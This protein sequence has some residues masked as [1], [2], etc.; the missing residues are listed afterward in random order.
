[1]LVVTHVARVSPD[2]TTLSAVLFLALLL[3][4]R[5]ISSET[6]GLI[7]RAAAYLG[8]VLLVYLDVSSSDPRSWFEPASWVLVGITA[9]ASLGAV[10]LDHRRRFDVTA[11]DLL[12]VVLA[13]LI[14]NLPGAMTLQPVQAA[15]ITKG[16]ILVYAVEI[17]HHVELRPVVKAGVVATALGAITLHGALNLIG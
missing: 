4:W 3:S 15:G 13:V 17:L 10:A 16:I 6:S 8:A 9:L 12:I 1:V 11:L 7:E 2:I 14:P 5:R